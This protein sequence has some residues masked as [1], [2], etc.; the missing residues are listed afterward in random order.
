MPKVFTDNVTLTELAEPN[1][2]QQ[3]A[4][5][6][7]V[8]VAYATPEKQLILEI[9][10]DT[11]TTVRQAIE[12]SGIIEEFPEIDSHTVKIGV[13]GKLISDTYQLQ[14]KDRLEIYRPL[15]ADPKEVRRR[16]AAEGKTM[17]KK[18]AAT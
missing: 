17:G 6:I 10:I 1:Q 3:K 7:R 14:E 15:L 16:L 11:A 13:F 12:L 9:E 4:S 18:K 2:D 8:E 5:P